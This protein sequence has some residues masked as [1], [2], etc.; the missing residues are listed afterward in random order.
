MLKKNK[1]IIIFT[2]MIMITSLAVIVTTQSGNPD[3]QFYRNKLLLATDC[4][5]S[6]DPINPFN[7]KKYNT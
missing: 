1:I 7:S 5:T 2:T 4:M 3:K 6:K